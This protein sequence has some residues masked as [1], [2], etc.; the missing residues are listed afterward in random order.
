IMNL[1]FWPYISAAQVSPGQAW[2]TGL[3]IREAIK[4]YAIF[5]AATSLWWDAWRAAGNAILIVSLGTP[6]LK[7]LRRFEHVLGFVMDTSI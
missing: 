6:L 1:W 2:E 3:P 5:Y 4:R 7:V